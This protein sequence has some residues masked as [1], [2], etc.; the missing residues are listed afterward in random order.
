MSHNLRYRTEL[1]GLRAIAVFAVV[2]Y[3]AK[4]SILGYAVFKGGFFG[5]DIFFV[6]SG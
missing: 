6:L 3:H 1:D 4:L 5:V 2:F